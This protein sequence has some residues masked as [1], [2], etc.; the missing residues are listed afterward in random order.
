MRSGRAIT[1]LVGEATQSDRV[2]A[3]STTCQA[4]VIDQD[5]EEISTSKK[6]KKRSTGR[7][8]KEIRKAVEKRRVA[9]ENKGMTDLTLVLFEDVD[10]LFEDDR[11]FMAALGKLALN[12]KCP[13]VLTYS[14]TKTPFREINPLFNLS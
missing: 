1:K 4:V 14:G 5:E 3:L 12:S 2:A 11:G 6:K 7:N 8:K 9:M 10:I 13:I